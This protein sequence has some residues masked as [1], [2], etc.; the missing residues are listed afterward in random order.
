[1]NQES[2]V[3]QVLFESCFFSVKQVS[4]VPSEWQLNQDSWLCDSSL[5]W[6]M[7]HVWFKSYLSHLT[8]NQESCHEWF[9]SYLTHMKHDSNKTWI[10]H[11]S[12]FNWH[13]TQ[14][15]HISARDSL[16]TLQFIWNEFE[17]GRCKWVTGWDMCHLR[18]HFIMTLLTHVTTYDS[19]TTVACVCVCVCVCCACCVSVCACAAAA[20]VLYLCSVY[21]D[22]ER[23]CPH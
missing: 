14:M 22:N 15:T 19:R 16:A 6:V 13:M 23:S 1:M 8:L 2:W 3:I 21:I 10:T 4:Q 12:W 9:K 18:C 20:L 7:F 17:C 11:D 5:I